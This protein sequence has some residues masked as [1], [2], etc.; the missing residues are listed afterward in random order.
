MYLSTKVKNKDFSLNKILEVLT[1]CEESIYQIAHRKL[2]YQSIE[3]I[4]SENDKLQ[5]ELLDKLKQMLLVHKIDKH[6]VLPNDNN[7]KLTLLGI[8]EI[9][10]PEFNYEERKAIKLAVETEVLKRIN[11]FISR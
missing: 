4:A 1:K 9:P 6:L 11:C 10:K 7:S 5:P 3:N 2:I 8:E